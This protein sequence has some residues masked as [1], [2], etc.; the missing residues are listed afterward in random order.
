MLKNFYVKI[1]LE[2]KDASKLQKIK[3]KNKTNQKLQKQNFSNLE[4]TNTFLDVPHIPITTDKN[5]PGSEGPTPINGNNSQQL[6]SNPGKKQN[7]KT[8]SFSQTND[9]AKKLGVLMFIECS[10]CE[11]RLSEKTKLPA[12]YLEYSFARYLE[13]LVITAEKYYDSAEFSRKQP[14]QNGSYDD[15]ES[16]RTFLESLRDIER[17]PN[18]R[19]C[20]PFAPKNRVFIVKDLYIRFRL[21]LS[22]Q[23]NLSMINYNDSNGM[24]TYELARKDLIES[25]FTHLFQLERNYLNL[26]SHSFRQVFMYLIE[27]SSLQTKVDSLEQAS[28]ELAEVEPNLRDPYDILFLELFPYYEEIVELSQKI[29]GGMTKSIRHHLEVEELK[30]TFYG[31]LTIIFGELQR[32]R[33]VYVNMIQEILGK[34][35]RI[36]TL[37]QSESSTMNQDPKESMISLKEDPNMSR[38]T[39]AEEDTYWMGRS[40]NRVMESTKKSSKLKEQDF[41]KEVGYVGDLVSGAIVYQPDHPGQAFTKFKMMPLYE[42]Q[43]LSIIANALNSP[44]YMQQVYLAKEF[45]KAE[46]F[47]S[48]SSKVSTN[49]EFRE[50]INSRLLVS[51]FTLNENFNLQL[52]PI[53]SEAR[54]INHLLLSFPGKKGGPLLPYRKKK[55][56]VNLELIEDIA[57]IIDIQKTL[58]DGVFSEKIVTPKFTVIV[59]HPS[60]FEALRFFNNIS[61]EDYLGSISCSHDWKENN[62]GKTG[63][64]FIKTFDHRYVF[65]ELGKKEFSML[66]KFVNEYFKYMWETTG[67]K[68]P[69]LLTKIYGIYEI[70]GEKKSEYFI[71]MENL[72]FGTGSNLTVYDLKGSQL[73]RYSGKG[74][75]TALD[76]DFLI[77]RNGEPIPMKQ[78][79]YDFFEKATRNDS[80]FLARLKVVDYSL[81]LV[82]DEENRSLRMGIIDYLRIFDFEKQ[83]EYIGKKIIKG[84]QPTIITPEDYKERFQKSM[85]RCFTPAPSE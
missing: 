79:Q 40:S 54:Y 72:F 23:Y 53:E 84:A 62:G 67:E 61:L 13:N 12:S 59:Y 39:A 58:V 8:H 50:F 51:A 31:E 3:K 83:M 25:K 77:H 48:Q 68:K 43:P 36:R 18:V 34:R 1:T 65:K 57:G 46:K 4:R 71:A 14:S 2:I 70:Q 45:D 26:I 27:G 20:C 56:A 21:G 73:N 82:M 9:A 42:D 63:A 80:E 22:H 28:K 17:R 64:K 74:N 44:S 81:L 10:E 66:L 15:L 60:Q 52:A 85:R 69:S 29:E 75:S 30:R 33:E 11:N 37:M 5:D 16:A 78:E 38:T 47:I 41:E 6:R 19:P 76:T 24:I 55:G 32:I 49:T 35:L 7:R